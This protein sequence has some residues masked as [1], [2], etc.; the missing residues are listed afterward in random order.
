[1]AALGGHD[2]HDGR[3]PADPREAYGELRRDLIGVER[4]TLLRLRREGKV[5]QETAREI[6]R[7]LD[8]EEA[9]LRG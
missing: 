8:L 4:D 9:R 3:P 7:D 5:R 1:M 2:G 6:Q